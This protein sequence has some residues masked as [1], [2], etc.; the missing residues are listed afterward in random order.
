MMNRV[1][2]HPKKRGE[3]RTKQRHNIEWSFMF[4]SNVKNMEQSLLLK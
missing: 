2:T 3:E 4:H 1:Y